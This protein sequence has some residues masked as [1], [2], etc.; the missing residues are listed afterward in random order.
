MAQASAEKTYASFVNGFVSEATGLTFPENSA[1][2]IDNCD[3]DFAGTVRRRLGLKEEVDGLNMVSG[4]VGLLGGYQGY[5]EN[6]YHV[7]GFHGQALSKY[8]PAV[9]FDEIA[10][11]GHEWRH[12]GGQSDRNFYVIQI[13]VW[14]F[15]YDWDTESTTRNLIDAVFLGLPGGTD[16]ATLDVA[17][18][19]VLFPEGEFGIEPAYR[20]KL[21]SASGNGRLYFTST[22]HY[23]F[24]LEYEDVVSSDIFLKIFTV[25]QDGPSH[26]TI[27]KRITIK[28][29]GADNGIKSYNGV[30]Q[31]DFGIAVRD[32]IGVEDGIAPDEHPTIATTYFRYN[33]YNA[34]WPPDRVTDYET[35][36]SEYPAKNQQWYLGLDS[37]NVFKPEL[38]E[39]IEFGSSTQIKGKGLVNPLTGLRTIPT[40]SDGLFD[41]VFP[42]SH[43]ADEAFGAIAFFA[44]RLWLAGEESVDR[45]P[46]VYFSQI[47]TKDENA[48]LFMSENDPTAQYLNALLDTDGGV[49]YI[50]EADRIIALK[51]FASGMLV[52]ASNGVWFISGGASNFTASTYSIE[53]VGTIGTINPDSVIQGERAVVFWAENSI[54]AA[55]LPQQGYLPIITDLAKDT[56]FSY[57]NRIPLDA[58]K[59][60]SGVHDQLGKKFYWSWLD[61]K[62]NVYPSHSSFYNKMLILD[63]RTGAFS[64][65]SFDCDDANYFNSIAIPKRTRGAAVGLDFVVNN[66]GTEVLNSTGENVVVFKDTG[67]IDTTPTNLKVLGIS[68]SVFGDTR[69]FDL[70]DSSFVDYAFTPLED[71]RNFRSYITSGDEVITQP[72]REKKTTHVFSYFNKTE[73]GFE[74]QLGGNLMPKNPSGCTLTV[75]W[76]WSNSDRGKRWSAP[77]KAYRHK[78][79][80]A[81]TGTSDTFNDG[82]TV[83]TSRLKVRGRGKAA[84]FHYEAEDGKDMQLLGYTVQYLAEGVP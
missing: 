73:T 16:P 48:S 27:T 12:P 53:K 62:D 34:G 1:K 59:R 44:G 55:A 37:S 67:A 47:I 80:Y 23:P 51:P 49:I 65:Y 35:D 70:T 24:Y 74:Q 77:Q 63:E 69:M 36:R 50:P 52:F 7:E 68:L 72:H 61:D 39:K 54:F 75:K 17:H 66:S 2:D 3:I 81:P 57:Y 21:Q 32:F 64:K 18:E 9:P 43:E 6:P 22:A 14:L 83:V 31:R 30:Y 5:Y 4:V 45:P 78:Q 33:L 10:I 60:S 42:K 58:K 28:V 40:H 29:L 15:I 25:G 20:T 76:D 84:S 46:G 71:P 56:V 19:E 13:G 26:Q 41:N 79:G 8:V 11:S 38:L 82:N